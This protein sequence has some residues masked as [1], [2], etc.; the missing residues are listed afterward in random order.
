MPLH[1]F[2]LCIITNNNNLLLNTLKSIN[3]LPK[4]RS[5]ILIM[6]KKNKNI[7]DKY[8]LY[9]DKILK[10]KSKRNNYW[11]SIIENLIKN[12]I[13]K[14]F[15]LFEGEIFT[16]NLNSYIWNINDRNILF[17]IYHNVLVENKINSLGLLENNPHNYQWELRVMQLT[18]RWRFNDDISWLP[19]SNKDD[20]KLSKFRSDS[21]IFNPNPSS[22]FLNNHSRNNALILLNNGEYNLA[23][24]FFTKQIYETHSN[25]LKSKGYFGIGYCLSQY[26]VKYKYIQKLMILSYLL[27]YKK[28]LEPLYLL[29][30]K[31]IL[32]KKDKEVCNILEKYP[33][34]IYISEPP[35]NTLLVYKKEVYQ[36]QFL[37]IYAN[38]LYKVGK[39]STLITVL[40]ELLSRKYVNSS[41]KNE[42]YKLRESIIKK[43]K[44]IDNLNE[45]MSKKDNIKL[46]I[47]INIS[48]LENIQIISHSYTE[49]II[50]NNFGLEN[51]NYLG[52]KLN[53]I[54]DYCDKK[55]IFYIEKENNL[56]AKLCF[57]INKNYIIPEIPVLFHTLSYSI[58]IYEKFRNKNKT[59]GYI[60]SPFKVDN[61]LLI[62]DIQIFNYKYIF[63]YGDGGINDYY[64][65]IYLFLHGCG[66]L[67]SGSI[68]IYLDLKDKF[69][70]NII[71]IGN[72]S[73][74]Y[75]NQLKDILKDKDINYRKLIIDAKEFSFL[76]LIKN[77]YLN[78]PILDN[79]Y[80]LIISKNNLTYIDDKL[81]CK[82]EKDIL[83]S[84]PNKNYSKYIYYQ[85]NGDLLIYFLWITKKIIESNNFLADILVLSIKKSKINK[86][87]TKLLFNSK[88]WNFKRVNENLANYDI[89]IFKNS[90][91]IKSYL[92]IKNKSQMNNLY[93]VT[94]DIE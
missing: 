65:I 52:I 32:D 27:S 81:F 7:Y 90:D 12:K 40:N 59:F 36:Y 49:K 51:L 18:D 48:K 88:F 84:I 34:V 41:I 26:G 19:N 63:F 29:I 4:F 21:I 22:Y 16:G 17:K 77:F 24:F 79:T 9:F 70:E 1:S 68:D 86:L 42:T 13:Y 93:T 3:N 20:I 80:S 25:H 91:I 60:N 44:Y 61:K 76:K 46:N 39:Y 47:D 58:K 57:K 33:E 55:P 54:K 38:C 35:S 82:S 2:H 92:G 75:I 56:I 30:Q 8:N 23:K 6:S 87:M 37:Y 15:F 69:K 53:I 50:I 67:Y 83:E 85:Q 10:I 66:V 72:W 78:K 43:R 62:E 94:L 64:Y 14:V 71:F 5:K 31:A 11:N 45:T 73:V 28:F 89:I 74:K